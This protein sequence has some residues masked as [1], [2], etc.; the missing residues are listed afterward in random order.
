MQDLSTLLHES[1]LVQPLLDSIACG[2]MILDQHAQVVTINKALEAI[3]GPAHQFNKKGA[4]QSI[5][6][7][8]ALDETNGC[9]HIEP[10]HDCKMRRMVLSA[11]NQK[12]TINGK[13]PLEL[14]VNGHAKQVTLQ[15][16]V[17]P[18]FVHNRRFVV[19]TIVD[20]RPLK[21]A[22][23]THSENSFHNII[24]K[25]PKIQTLFKSIRKVAATDAAVLIQGES[26]T[27]KEMVAAA[28]H[29]ESHRHNRPFVPCNCGAL[30]EGVVESE[31]FGHVKGAFTNAIKDKKGRFELAHTGTLFLDEIGELHPS[32]QVRLLRVLQDGIF[33]RVG[34]EKSIQTDVRI[35]SATNKEINREINTGQFRKDLYY[36]LCVVP[37]VLPPLRDRKGDIP[38]LTDHFLEVY[39]ETDSTERIE[40]SPETTDI[41]L[42]YHWPG[43]I[44]ELQNVI[45]YSLLQNQG[46]CIKPRHL[47]PLLSYSSALRSPVKKRCKIDPAD[48]ALALAQTK[49]NKQKAAEVLGISRSTLYRFFNQLEK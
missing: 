35:I 8:W 2:V 18:F 24:G 45:Q 3:I 49:G 47:P 26:G 1:N 25:D 34:G 7:I 16:N 37:L 10:C 44:R 28:I 9:G 6:C 41:F 20:I 40:L 36:R 46:S 23:S 33:E 30:P 31:L 29:K 14:F 5:G 11:I 39:T 42:S 12:K 22:P 4:G 17:A 32:T 43:N 27:G 15:L 21:P 48:V 19:M 38:L 13:A